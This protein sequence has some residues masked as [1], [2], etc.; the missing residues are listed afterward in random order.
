MDWITMSLPTNAGRI[1]SGSEL[2]M[3]S[4]LYKL[5]FLELLLKSKTDFYS[6]QNVS[7][8][9]STYHNRTGYVW[10]KKALH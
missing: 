8:L 10:F 3:G 1:G 6:I 2:V 9:Y 5:I 7:V 4:F